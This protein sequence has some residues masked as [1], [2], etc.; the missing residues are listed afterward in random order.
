MKQIDLTGERFDFVDYSEG[1]I[2]FDTFSEKE[3]FV[4]KVWGATLMHELE[5]GEQD[6]YIADMS[7]LVFENVAYIS[8]NYGIYANEEGTKF[9][10]NMDG[11]STDMHLV[12]GKKENLSDYTEYIIGGILG[13]YAGYGEITIYC[14]GKIKLIYDEKALISATEFCLNTDKYRFY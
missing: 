1:N 11:N 9:I 2:F 12:L 5:I 14:K 8:I 7:E 13:R 10:K 3:T 4:I 6:I